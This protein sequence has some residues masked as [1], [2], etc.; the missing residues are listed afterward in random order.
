MTTDSEIARILSHWPLRY[1]V[2]TITRYTRPYEDFLAGVRGQKVRRVVV[3]PTRN[4]KYHIF[5]EEKD[6]EGRPQE[7]GV[8]NQDGGDLV[9]STFEEAARFLVELGVFEML[10][11]FST[12][13]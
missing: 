7:T 10:V 6:S 12:R 3:Y 11:N 1:K 4:G 13:R 9:F 2:L 5:A 8:L